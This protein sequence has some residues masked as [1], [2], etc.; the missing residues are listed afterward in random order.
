MLLGLPCSYRSGLGDTVG[1]GLALADASIRA[2]RHGFVYPWVAGY[3][4]SQRKT[5]NV[6]SSTAKLN[7]NR[8]TLKRVAGTFTSLCHR[9]RQGRRAK[10]RHR[11]G[12]LRYACCNRPGGPPSSNGRI[13]SAFGPSQISPPQRVCRPN[14]SLLEGGGPVVEVSAQ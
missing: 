1:R 13:T 14:Q 6:S 11:V 3:L 8:C 5:G 10:Q 7:D 4:L 9:D 12:G 2:T